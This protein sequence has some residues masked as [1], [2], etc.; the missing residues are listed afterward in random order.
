VSRRSVQLLLPLAVMALAGCPSAGQG[1]LP[2]WRPTS[3]ELG[4]G[5][6]QLGLRYRWVVE[7]DAAGLVIRTTD[8]GE[9]QLRIFACGKAVGVVQELIRQRLRDRLVGNDFIR[10][11]KAISLRYYPGKTTTGVQAATAFIPYGPLLIAVTSTT[12]EL[13]D[14]VGIAERVR[15]HLP[16]ATITG[17]Y[18]LCEGESKCVPQGPE[19]ES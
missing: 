9:A 4:Q 8:G 14:L 16:I 6:V 12:L 10:H 15:L 17:C 19:G 18:P 1:E 3:V 11:A 5:S 7:R 13:S 2:E